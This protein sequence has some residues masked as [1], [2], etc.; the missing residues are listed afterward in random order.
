V[1]RHLVLFRV[2]GEDAAGV[3]AELAAALADLGA[4]VPDLLGWQYGPNLTPDPLAADCALVADFPDRRALEA[5]FE[6]P[7]HLALL[8]RFE[9]QVEL[10][11]ADLNL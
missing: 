7:A 5:Y 11:F 9:G 8:A 10:R 4:R 6:H 1:I 3:A 2:R